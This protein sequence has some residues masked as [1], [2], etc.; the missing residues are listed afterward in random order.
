M[1]INKKCP[2]VDSCDEVH[3][4]CHRAYHDDC[5]HLGCEYCT[6]YD[7]C[8]GCH[9]NKKT[10]VKTIEIPEGARNIKFYKKDW[11]VYE[12]Y[13]DA[14]DKL[15]YEI[16]EQKPAEKMTFFEA[17]KKAEEGD[18]IKP[19]DTKDYVIKNRQG[20]MVWCKTDRTTFLQG[21]LFKKEWTIVPKE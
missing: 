10:V 2:K 12:Y 16:E 19:S 21:W 13:D 14:M 8:R 3:E 6:K 18:K 5:T 9:N 20:N 17:W 1:L 4:K 7:P 11:E 15:T